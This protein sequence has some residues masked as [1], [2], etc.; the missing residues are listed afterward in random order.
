MSTTINQRTGSIT[1]EVEPS[2]M[3]HFQVETPYLAA[4]AK[5]SNLRVVVD[6]NDASVHAFRGE[7][8]VSDFRAGQRVRI[9]DRTN[10]ENFNPAPWPV[11]R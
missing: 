4:V 1:L 2:D 5:G 3:K 7:V 10:R 6:D 11:F 9:T 8:E